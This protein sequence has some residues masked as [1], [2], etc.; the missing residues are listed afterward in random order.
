LRVP[1]KIKNILRHYSVPETEWQE[2]EFANLGKN[3]NQ[4]GE[5]ELKATANIE[6]KEIKLPEEFYLLSEAKND[7]RW[8]EVATWYL[9]EE[10]GVDPAGYD[11]M[12]A[13]KSGDMFMRK[14][15][16][17]LVIPIYKDGKLIFFQG[18]DL[19]GKKTKKYESPAVA[20]DKILFGYEKLFNHS[21]LPLYVVEI[22]GV[23]CQNLW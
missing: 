13:K 18:R 14:W 9:K 4:A 6:P 17:R 19:T 20:K 23:I 11:Y 21:E 3:P 8:A 1:R 12:L 10:R 2:V 15:L 7:D 5:L 22:T 16:G